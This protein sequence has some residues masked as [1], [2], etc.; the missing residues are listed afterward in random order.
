MTTG[1]VLYKTQ[2]RGVL[3]AVALAAGLLAAAA[4]ADDMPFWG[5]TPNTNRTAAVS[6]TA[7]IAKFSS[8]DFFSRDFEMDRFDSTK[9][10][11]TIIVF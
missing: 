4:V 5:D 1:K 3:G 2:R 8:A 9:N 10:S 6:Q 7:A 11:F